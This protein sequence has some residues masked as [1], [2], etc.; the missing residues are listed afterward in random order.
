MMKET[1]SE[2]QES[3]AFDESFSNGFEKTK[4][5]LSY[6]VSDIMKRF[7]GPDP[8]SA[9]ALVRD[10]LHDHINYM[11]GKAKEL[12]LE[13]TSQERPMSEWLKET[14]S[15]FDPIKIRK[16]N[17]SG[18]TPVFHGRLLIIGLTL[19]EPQ[20][21][22]QFE[23]DGLFEVLI[24]EIQEPFEEILTKRGR[25]LF[26]SPTSDTI[27]SDPEDSVPNQPDDPLR[28]LDE[29][30]LGRAAFA[31]Y[32]AKRIQAI[33]TDSGAYS[34]H[35]Y[36][37]WG[38]GKSTLLNF[39]GSQLKR[40]GEWIVTEFN[41]WRHQHIQPPWWS[42]LESVFQQTKQKLSL[43]DRF[44]EYWWRFSTGRTHYLI[45][46]IVLVWIIVLFAF[47]AL[48]DNTD[49]KNTLGNI[50]TSA[51]SLSKILAIIITIW[52]IV[53]A[54]S[55]SLL[56]GS[57]KAAQS[58]IELTHDSMN[59]IKERFNM[60]VTRLHPYKIAV[61]IDDIDRCQSKYVIDLLEGIQTLFKEAPVVFIVASDRKW[62]NACY[63]VI[64][65]KLKP[66]VGEPGKP[67]GVLF[68]EK[69]FQFSTSVP[70]IP[71]EFKE[72][73]WRNLIQVKPLGAEISIAEDRKK[74][75]EMMAGTGN[76]GDIVRLVNSSREKSF[77]EQRAIREEAVIRLATPE[78]VERTEHTLMPFAEFLKPNP[79]AMKRLVNAYSVNRA[80]AILSHIDVERDQLVLWTILSL[81]WPLLAEYLEKNPDAVGN[82]IK[83]SIAN[84]PKNLQDLVKDKD[85][86]SVLKGGP[87]RVV[88]DSNVIKQCA[89]LRG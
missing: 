12:P 78:I 87:T 22:L 11:G 77:Q 8:V 24:G 43:G 56:L 86:L 64:Y 71:K 32:L 26:E 14:Q 39:L 29:D 23:Q 84:I 49:S 82:I 66:W 21:R 47:P 62:L 41:A 85:V 61:L 28:S 45:G 67:I 88:L 19:L 79:R 74:A 17:K 75:K 36:G 54:F 50:A 13:E 59:E 65:A 35:V 51:D 34:I 38:S 72:A 31:Q 80:I 2:A 15:L 68:L 10:I 20:L 1:E 30:Q 18:S 9:S 46:F 25:K 40:D 6:S 16:F 4:L 33:P 44:L 60:L 53:I 3:K 55:R 52:G 73:Y 69:A 37:P 5:E 57:S 27:T 83:Q 63:E 42:L 89:F 48:H 7:S 58:Y 70:G 81:R 76:E